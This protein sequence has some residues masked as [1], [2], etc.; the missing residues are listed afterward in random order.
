MISGQTKLAGNSPIQP[1]K[2]DMEITTQDF[3]L[4][5]FLRLKGIEPTDLRDEGRRHLFV[6]TDDEKF[7]ALKRA[8][9]YDEAQVPPQMFK[10]SIR[11]L[12]A[13]ISEG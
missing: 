12:K 11:E 10:R 5:A 2:I 13:L 4:T 6:F 3:Y 7:R 1:E 9:Y 8:Y